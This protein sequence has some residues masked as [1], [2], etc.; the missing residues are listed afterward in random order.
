M[1]GELTSNAVFDAALAVIATCMTMTLCSASPANFAGIAAV[2]LG[3]AT[4]TVGD[5][6]G[7]YT[8]ADGPVS[9]RKLT[10]AAQVGIVPTANGTVT[11]IA[12]D[13]GV[14]LHEVVATTSQA[15]TTLQSWDSPEFAIKMTDPTT[16]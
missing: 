8:I 7:D 9:G 15:V 6:N 3:K 12:F 11:H 4:L 1:A 13:D 16:A 10:V 14:T 2:E 5:G